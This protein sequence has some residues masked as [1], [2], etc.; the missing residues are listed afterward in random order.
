MQAEKINPKSYARDKPSDCAHCY[1]WKPKKKCCERPECYYLILDKA[2]G[3]KEASEKSKTSTSEEPGN[4]K[5]CPYGRSSP[6]F[7]YCIKKILLEMNQK[8]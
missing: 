6:C 2:N 7:G 5:T 4:C 1:F 8:K 3:A